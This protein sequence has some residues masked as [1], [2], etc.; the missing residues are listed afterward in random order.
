LDE[1]GR[2]ETIA[3]KF[4]SRFITIDVALLVDGTWKIVEVGDGGVSGL[5]MGLDP[6]K[7]YASLWNRLAEN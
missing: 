1:L 2:W 6:A 3:A 4:S 5:P 7:F